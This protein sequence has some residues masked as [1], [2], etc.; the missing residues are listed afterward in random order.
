MND[1]AL[2]ELLAAISLTRNTSQGYLFRTVLIAGKWPAIDIY[3]EVIGDSVP[4]NYCF[5][6]VKSTTLGYT[7]RDNKLRI[8]IPKTKLNKLAE[9]NGPSYLI[10]IDYVE[11]NPFDSKAYISAIR[12]TYA[13]GFSSMPTNNLLDE[14][15]LI[16]LK[17]EVETFW[18]GTNTFDKKN[19]TTSIFDL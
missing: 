7:A 15:N 17:D 12:G 3:A 14:S 4:K 19:S 11:S 8:Q 5:I 13:T 9:F 2:S 6:Q 16:R 18:N 10:G 1:G